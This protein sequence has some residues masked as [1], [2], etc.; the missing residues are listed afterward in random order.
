MG[1]TSGHH[2]DESPAL[3]LINLAKEYPGVRA[4]T[5]VSFDVRRARVHAL[6]G[7]NG[8]GK[9][10][11]I[12]LIAGTN[13]PTAGGIEIDGVLH[14]TIT[15]R[16]ARAL[17]IRLVPQERQV[18]E[19]LTVAENVLLG[20]PPTRSALAVVDRRAMNRHASERLAHVGLAAI[21]PRMSMRDLTVVQTQLVEVA[22]AMSSNARLIIMDEPTAA[23]GGAD[24]QTLFA[25]IRRLRDHGVSFL[26]VSHHLEE[27]FEVADD[28][29]VLRDARHVVT[30]EVKG[31][32][33]DELVVL[34][35]G[36][37]P[38]EIQLEQLGPAGGDALIEVKDVHRAPT[39]RGVSMDVRAGEV[40]A[41]TGGIGS[42]RRELARALVGIEKPHAGEVRIAG[43]GVVRGP[44]H[45][46]RC[47]VALVPEDRKNEGI[48]AALDVAD[49]IG[50]GRLA[51]ARHVLNLPR[52]RRRE[53]VDMVAHLRVKTPSIHQPVRLLSGGNQQKA[54]L[55][56]WLNVGVR[57]LV[58]DGP[59][60]GIDIGSRLEIY[61]LL[62]ELAGQGVAVV[63]CSSDFEEVKLVADRVVVLR[64]GRVAGELTGGAISEERLY[65]LQYG[66]RDEEVP[67]A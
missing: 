16:A 12:S 40:L 55:G 32:T 18:C 1:H 15:P 28:V 17:G 25:G 11:L 20:A 27:I 62:R 6:V 38:E 22:R 14:P 56:R 52:R 4:L 50:L 64:R 46:V 23:L 42:G 48:L 26:Y 31:L 19:D 33:V 13:H 3:R 63:I 34:L 36:R 54:L 65:A 57:C 9:S 24:V 10:T 53:A 47:G 41:V 58:L 43:A 35:L 66:K 29:T 51:A 7:E 2:S 59:T 60:E 67:A 37:S 5:G 49:N 21:D 61:A 30:R 39:L 44:A 45:A 8:A